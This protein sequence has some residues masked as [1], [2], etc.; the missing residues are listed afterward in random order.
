MIS[1]RGS[2]LNFTSI[3]QT[4]NRRVISI[5]GANNQLLIPF[6]SKCY[7]FKNFITFLFSR[8]KK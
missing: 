3:R 2:A 4:E 8:F 7:F 6:V 5:V 1:L